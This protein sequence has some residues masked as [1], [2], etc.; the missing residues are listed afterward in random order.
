MDA[1]KN[2]SKA[3]AVGTRIKSLRQALH[4]SQKDFAAKINAAPSQLS[5]IEAGKAKPGY[6]FLFKTVS[7]ISVNANW[8]L[9]GA[10]E[11]FLPD[12]TKEITGKTQG[13]ADADNFDFGSHKEDIMEMLHYCTNS[14]LVRICMLAHF[15][16]FYLNNETIIRRD[17]KKFEQKKKSEG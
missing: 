17:M 4:L 6:H 1:K 3:H 7:S 8:L 5:A 16:Q 2:D 9:S 13:A 12:E 14:P 10:G 11:M 15:S